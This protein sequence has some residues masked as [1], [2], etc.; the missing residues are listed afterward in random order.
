[1]LLQALESPERAHTLLI[2]PPA[3]AI[4]V[5]NT[6]FQDG[7]NAGF[8][9]GRKDR[10]NGN[11][12]DS[13]RPNGHSDAY[14]EGYRRGYDDGS[15]RGEHISSN[16]AEGGGDDDGHKHRHRDSVAASSSAAAAAGILV[17]IKNL[18]GVRQT[19]Y[20]LKLGG[21]MKIEAAI[22][23]L[24]ELKLLHISKK[25]IRVS[26]QG[27]GNVGSFTA[28][29]LD[30]S[31]IKVVAISDVSG[32]IYNKDGLNIP[33]LMKDIKGKTSFS[34]IPAAVGDLITDKNSIEVT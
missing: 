9:A 29:F 22:E 21:Y 12:F 5:S 28:K 14:D 24:E 7:Y 23:M 25:Q 30:S 19:K 13:K 18:I 3:C 31:G 4:K 1:M 6:S 32:F 2:G 11:E 17:L 27:F 20:Y 26:V 15:F 34:D 16:S 10:I 8:A 33:R